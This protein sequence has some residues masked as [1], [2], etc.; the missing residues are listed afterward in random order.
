MTEAGFAAQ[1]FVGMFEKLQQSNRLNDSGG[2]AYLRSH[3]L[4]TERISDMQN[5]MPLSWAASQSTSA[6]VSS[7]LPWSAQDLEPVLIGARARVLSNGGVDGLR[8]WQGDLKPAVLSTKPPAQ[9]A[10]A[11]YGGAFAALKLRDYAQAQTLCDQLRV[12]VQGN[13]AA[14]HLAQLLDA[15]IALT[16]GNATRALAVLQSDSPVA[17]RAEKFLRAQAQTLQAQPAG[18]EQTAQ[19]LRAWVI[20]RPRDAKGWSLLAA[21]YTAQGRNVAAVRAQAQ[22]D[23]LQLDYAAA[24]ARL[25]AAQ[26]LVRSGNWG[27]MGPDHLEAAIV[28]TRAREV[29]QL[30]REQAVER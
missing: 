11:L 16:Q 6:V 24:L 3:P 17:S 20:E 13:A 9:Q 23:L 30:T 1:G 2:F 18:I 21:A 8:V 14:V 29:L 15:E 12:R 7:T 19:A 4:T 22:V 28:D 10:A 5:R 26:D 25:R 27:P